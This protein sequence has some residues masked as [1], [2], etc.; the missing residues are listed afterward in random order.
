MRHLLHVDAVKQT[1]IGVCA[2][3]SNG[4]CDDAVAKQIAIAISIDAMGGTYHN[5]NGALT[6]RAAGIAC[7]RCLG[8]G[9]RSDAWRFCAWRGVARW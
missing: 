8:H 7:S 6:L 9:G 2:A 4:I 3:N 1:A 5:L